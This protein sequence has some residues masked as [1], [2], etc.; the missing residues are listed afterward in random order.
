MK[1]W[2][3]SWNKKS[4]NLSR[5]E[6]RGG[7][8]LVSGSSDSRWRRNWQMTARS[9]PSLSLLS[10]AFE[11]FSHH[12]HFHMQTEK[13]GKFHQPRHEITTF[14]VELT[15]QVVLFPLKIPNHGH[16]Q[17]GRWSTR[18]ADEGVDEDGPFDTFASADVN[19]VQSALPRADF[20]QGLAHDRVTVLMP[21][22]VFVKFHKSTVY[23]FGSQT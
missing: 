23:H 11:R 15:S 3:L 2:G 14:G 18:A 1:T 12:I 17:N 19:D 16:P 9:S 22:D 10:D 6:R 8:Q 7:K 20:Q 13:A 5:G 21:R 4:R